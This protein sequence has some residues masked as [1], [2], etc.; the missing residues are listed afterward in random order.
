[1]IY[2]TEREIKELC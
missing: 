1:M 2:I